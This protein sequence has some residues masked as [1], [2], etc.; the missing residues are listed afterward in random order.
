MKVEIKA[1]NKLEG[2]QVLVFAT[3]IATPTEAKEVAAMLKETAQVYRA[4]T[5]LDDWEKVLRVECAAYTSVRYIEQCLRQAGYV[6]VEL[7]H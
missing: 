3:D 5:D 1:L 4:T 6:C 2:I 7:T